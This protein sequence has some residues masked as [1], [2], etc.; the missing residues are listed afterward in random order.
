MDLQEYIDD[1]EAKN[2][3]SN[4]DINEIYKKLKTYSKRYISDRIN[5]FKSINHNLNDNIIY[6]YKKRLNDIDNEI[7]KNFIQSKLIKNN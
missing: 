3:I 6:D 1:L 2:E 5:Y 7:I 4:K